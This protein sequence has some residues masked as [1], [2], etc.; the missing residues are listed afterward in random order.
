[1]G[2][3]AGANEGRLKGYIVHPPTVKIDFVKILCEVGCANFRPNAF[4]AAKRISIEIWVGVG[5]HA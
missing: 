4:A 3:Y 5:L 1:M 2:R